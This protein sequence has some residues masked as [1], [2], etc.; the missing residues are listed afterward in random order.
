MIET[1]TLICLVGVTYHY[2][3][4][5]L[6]LAAWDR[7]TRTPDK[8]PISDGNLRQSVTVILCVHN[9]AFLLAD[10]L[11]NIL[12]SAPT[13]TEIIVVS[14]GSTDDT[15]AI[16]RSFLDRGVRLVVQSPRQGKGQAINAGMAIANGSI[17]VLTD[18][19][20]TFDSGA[21]G[22]LIRTFADPS[23]CIASGALKIRNDDTN[24]SSNLVGSS[25]G[26]YWR[27]ESEIRRIETSLGS[28]VSVVGPILALR[29]SL[30]EPIPPGVINDDAF[31]ALRTL[32]SGH[33]VVF[34]PDA[35]CW[36]SPSRDLT[37]ERERRARM[38]AGR[39]QLIA[40]VQLWP[41]HS[42]KLLLFWL[43]H[44]VLRILS[45]IMLVGAGVGTLFVLASD[46]GQAS[47]A[48]WWTM[49]APQ[50]ALYGLALFG[51]AREKTARGKKGI[52]RLASLAALFVQVN[53]GAAAGF[54][55]YALGRQSTQ[56]K[57]TR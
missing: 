43:S 42:P 52:A 49:A 12:D 5:P 54:W 39:Y 33:R 11:I 10:R 23:V 53:L 17:A 55:R 47:P 36:R 8:L 21:I 4:Y 27:Y 40:S 35:V 14:D 37:R 28:T 41:F 13:G 51:L 2:I 20:A 15:D 57:K 26:L 46:T 31:L 56:W 50:I 29:R 22:K 34:V 24:D 9:E 45:P 32:R 44:K 48:F 6:L 16:A 1:I 7:A 18:A 3:G 19:N 25:E 30:W 38:G